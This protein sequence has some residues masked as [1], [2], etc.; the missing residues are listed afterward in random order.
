MRRENQAESEISSSNKAPQLL[1][2]LATF[3]KEKGSWE[4]CSLEQ[5]KT[6]SRTIYNEYMTT[7]A[8]HSALNPTSPSSQP[9]KLDISNV[10]AANLE[11]Q[12]HLGPLS[13]RESRALALSKR[14]NIPSTKAMPSSLFTGDQVLSN[15][16]LFMRDALYMVEFAASMREGDP[17][18]LF[19]VMDVSGC[20]YMLSF[21]IYNFSSI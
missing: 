16:K 8:Y 17:G 1:E 20:A 6:L 21:S 9:S 19:G 14:Q 15:G 2:E 13:A 11:H 7:E 3:F 10:L 5:L 18:R 12:L 4:N